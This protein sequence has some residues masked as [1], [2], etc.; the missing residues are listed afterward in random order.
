[1]QAVERDGEVFRIQGATRYG[2]P[3]GDI[4]ADAR[5]ARVRG[6]R[7]SEAQA[8]RMLRGRGYEEVAEVRRE[9]DQLLARA[10]RGGTPVELRINA[11]SGAVTGTRTGE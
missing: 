4:E 5:T 9:G 6:E 10:R 7:L 8:R 1:M 3:V 11:L 2:E